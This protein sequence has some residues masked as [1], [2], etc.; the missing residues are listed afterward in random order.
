[1]QR[2]QV[3]VY[4]DAET[5]EYVDREPDEQAEQRASDLIQRLA[6]MNFPTEAGAVVEDGKLIPHLR[7]S[8]DAQIGRAHV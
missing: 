7:F 4:P 8:D 3:T 2:F 5:W 1:M 6:E